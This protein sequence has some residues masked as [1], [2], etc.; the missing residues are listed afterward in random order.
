[1]KYIVSDPHRFVYFV[2][3]KVACSSVK[4]VL[5]PLFP[6]DVD[7]YRYTDRFGAARIRVHKA[8]DDSPAQIDQAEML[9]SLHRLAGHFKFGF[10][11]NPW[12][13]LLSCFTQKL[14]ADKS[15]DRGDGQPLRQ[16][17]DQ[18]DRF[19]IGMPFA[20]FVEGVHATPDAQADSHFQ[21][22]WRIFYRTPEPGTLLA[23]FIGRFENLAQDFARV[24]ER[25]PA[26]AGTPL[27]H[28]LKSRTRPPGPFES[29]YDARSRALVAERYAA[30]I[31]LFGYGG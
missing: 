15:Q 11:R 4:R 9:A 1:M 16:P 17:P 3:P 7:A 13:R 6:I 23:D 5:L 19:Y 28:E 27:P 8:F 25:I 30:D 2:T 26:L 24:T 21:S 18:P 20:E 10:V 22:Q 29:C 14:H 31:A 12:D